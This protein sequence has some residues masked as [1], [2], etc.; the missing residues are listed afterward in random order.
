MQH[1][2]LSILAKASDYAAYLH[3]LEVEREILSLYLERP[4]S[5]TVELENLIV[6]K[7]ITREPRDYR[8]ASL[9]AIAA[10]QLF[11]KGVK[12]RPGQTV[13]YII[14]DSQSTVPNDRVRLC[15]LGRM[16]RPQPTEIRR[17]TPRSLRTVRAIHGYPT[18]AS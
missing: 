10:Q 13:E 9:A 17:N 6:S 15:A 12:L 3:K 18:F 4:A 14:T 5:G 11:G 8:K 7:R 1:E 16:A 2:V